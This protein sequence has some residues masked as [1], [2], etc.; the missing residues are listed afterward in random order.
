MHDPGMNTDTTKTHLPT[1][2]LDIIRGGYAAFERGDMATVF[3][4]LD[5]DVEF[6]QSNG[7]PWGGR[8]RGLAQVQEFF[9]KLTTAVESTVSTERFVEAGDQVVQIGRT[10]GQARATAK[11][12]DVLEVHVWT[13]RH[14]KVV[15]FEAYVD[16]PAMLAALR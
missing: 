11:T 12:F 13:L 3:A 10:R 6:Y 5:S 4:M 2:N 14:G 9:R 7:V 15:R 1:T 16:Q 8:Y